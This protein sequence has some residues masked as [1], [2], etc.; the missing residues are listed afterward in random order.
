MTKERT[1]K[2]SESGHSRHYKEGEK[3]RQPRSAKYRYIYLCGT[4]K[5]KKEMRKMLKYPVFGEYPKGDSRRYDTND[6][7]GVAI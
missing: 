7:H 1:D 2:F 6:P 4:K 3:R 5:Q